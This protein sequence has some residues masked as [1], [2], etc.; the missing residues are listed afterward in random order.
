M[1]FPSLPLLSTFH[2][3]NI[4]LL[5]ALP[6]KRIRAKQAFE[7]KENGERRGAHLH[8]V[9]CMPVCPAVCLCLSVSADGS[10]RSSSDGTYIAKHLSKARPE[11]E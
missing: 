1:T 2:V 4:R 6:R 10:L 9:Y 3:F 11:V 5:Q 7:M 8:R